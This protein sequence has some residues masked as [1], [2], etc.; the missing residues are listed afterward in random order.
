MQQLLII[1]ILAFLTTLVSTISFADILAKE[2]WNACKVAHG[3]V[4]SNPMEDKFR[5][6]IYTE[7]KFKIALHNRLA[8]EGHSTFFMKINRFGD[9]FPSEIAALHGLRRNSNTSQ[10]EH[11]AATFIAPEGFEAPTEIDWRSKGAV[12]EV[13]DQGKCGSCYAMAVAGS[14]EGQHFRKTGEL[15][16]LSVQQLVDCTMKFEY[17]DDDEGC[18]GGNPAMTFKYILDNKGLD[19]DRSYP[20][21]SWKTGFMQ[22]EC[23]FNKSTI[24]ATETGYVQIPKENEDELALAVAAHGPI[25]IGMDASSFGFL[26]YSHGIYDNSE[27]GI[28]CSKDLDDSDHELL[29]VGYGP[30]YWLV[31]NSWGKDWGMEGYIKVKR[32]VNM[33]GIADEALFPLV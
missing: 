16:P 24:G 29:V 10:T 27:I 3:K 7:N 21:V 13:K 31:K 23:H 32:G 11:M 18:E 8:H 1:G 20:Y 15:I 26:H 17:D 5:M 33:C 6:K 14:L 9:F 12:T 19:T 28:K 4:Y 30:G 22:K 25:A 2:E